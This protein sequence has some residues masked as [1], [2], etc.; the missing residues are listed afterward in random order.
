MQIDLVPAEVKPVTEQKIMCGGV[1]LGNVKTITN[2]I[3]AP[4]YHVILDSQHG[5][6]IYQGFGDT[7]DNAM[8]DA[9]SNSKFCREQELGELNHL[10][11]VI[12]GDHE[13][14]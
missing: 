11:N 7:V 1:C 4:R 8:R 2:A 9:I 5:K 6:N 14:N 10:E 13:I 12:W 3:D